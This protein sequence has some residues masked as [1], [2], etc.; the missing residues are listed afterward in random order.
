MRR[1]KFRF[2]KIL[3][4]KRHLETQRQR[5]LAEVRHREYV[6]RETLAAIGRNRSVVQEQEREHLTGRLNP[7]RLTGYSRYYLRLKQMEMAGRE[8]LRQI[9]REAE[10][11]RQALV[12]AAKQKKIYETLRQRYWD[13]YLR[14]YNLSVQKEN[15]EIGQKVYLR[16][17]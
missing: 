12:A 13:R 17:R 5:E 1:F 9:G 6:Q 7:A 15:D 8:V 14:E 2:E 3:R 4:Y 16:N 11:R 10:N